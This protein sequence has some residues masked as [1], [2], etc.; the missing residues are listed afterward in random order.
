MSDH[1]LIELIREV[2]DRVSIEFNIS[3]LVEGLKAKF[4]EKAGSS[5]F[6]IL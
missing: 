1:L 2:V 3:L 5:Q 4:I 6:L